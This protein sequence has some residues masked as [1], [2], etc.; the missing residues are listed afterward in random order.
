MSSAE[1]ADTSSSN[2][3]KDGDDDGWDA[4]E[5]NA[6]DVLDQE[7][8]RKCAEARGRDADELCSGKSQICSGKAQ[9]SSAASASSPAAAAAASAP[10]GHD[11]ILRPS[12]VPAD[13]KIVDSAAETADADKKPTES[14]L[15]NDSQR[16][17]Q[18]CRDERYDPEDHMMT[19]EE[20]WGGASDS[21]SD[22]SPSIAISAAL[23]TAARDAAQHADAASRDVR[24]LGSHSP[25]QATRGTYSPTLPDRRTAYSPQPH[26]SPP[27]RHP[28]GPPM[29]LQDGRLRRILAGPEAP[30][31][32]KDLS[33]E[34]L[35][36]V[37]DDCQRSVATLRWI[38]QRQQQ[39]LSL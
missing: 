31:V 38:L 15:A 26:S 23:E 22:A 20:M 11:G 21:D 17:L 5:R 30:N 27:M 33:F 3:T 29:D 34:E 9:S 13:A 37:A 7:L 24:S 16:L 36:V 14:L 18:A 19:A 39:M 8:E 6:M 2:W 35:S 25:A 32:L 12:D 1:E 28:M 4:M 10:Q